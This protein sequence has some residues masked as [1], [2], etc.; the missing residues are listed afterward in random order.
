[1][2]ERA[3]NNRRINIRRRIV[4]PIIILIAIYL[5]GTL[6]YM[7]IEK[8]SF[9]QS[10]FMSTI[11][12]STVGLATGSELSKTGMLYTVFFII[13]STGT[14]AYIVIN[15]ADLVV[16]NF[17]MGNFEGRRLKKMISRLKNHYIICGFGRVGDEIAK[18]LEK[19]NIP[20]VVIDKSEEFEAECQKNNWL[21]IRGDATEDEILEEANIKDARGLLAAIGED[22]ENIY[23]VLSAKS[24][25]P[26]MIIVARASSQ[27]AKN[28]LKKAGADRIITPEIIGAQR[29]ASLVL[30]PAVVGFLDGVL[31]TEKLEMELA[32]IEVKP[33]SR[34]AN[35]SIKDASK[36]Y[37]FGALII[38]IV[39]VG[40]EF[41]LIKASG[42]TI[43]REG[44]KL[45]AIGTKEQ[46]QELNDLSFE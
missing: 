46:I 39:D 40:E 37:K 11:T 19:Q 29:M 45:I 14:A 36:K 24:L 44:H 22:S 13:I 3:V 10:L 18:A 41:S 27:E 7:L 17:L 1:M 34:V 9:L 16:Q 23:T 8:W 12:V 35:M 6:G 31:R 33:G 28:K 25:N 5:L 26:G 42:D 2:F 20:F 43:F 32:E 38:S 4:I 30:Q 21:Y 15:T